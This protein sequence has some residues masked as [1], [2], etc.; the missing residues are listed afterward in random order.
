MAD[1]PIGRFIV[2]ETVC[3]NVELPHWLI[4]GIDHRRRAPSAVSIE[5]EDE[6]VSGSRRMGSAGGDHESI[7]GAE[8][9]PG[10]VP[11]VVEPS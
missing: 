2:V 8:A 11:S 10:P 6:D 1:T 5:V 4:E 9:V 7:K 3:R